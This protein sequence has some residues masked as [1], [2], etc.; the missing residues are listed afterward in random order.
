MRLSLLKE[1][2]GM[3]MN[4]S[5]GHYD[6][7]I[8]PAY[9]GSYNQNL[10]GKDGMLNEVFKDK[11]ETVRFTLLDIINELNTRAQ[12]DYA[13]TESINGKIS[14]TRTQLFA[15]E[16]WPTGLNQAVDK[17]RGA[18]EQKI[19]DLEEDLRTRD[20]KTL[21]DIAPLKSELRRTFIEYKNLKRKLQMIDNNSK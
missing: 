6:I 13:L 1:R 11:F 18:L 12:L 7:S 16:C 19:L 17:K 2:P 9:T 8:D 14:E 15:L 3:K 21:R 20:I 5:E 10:S 4:N